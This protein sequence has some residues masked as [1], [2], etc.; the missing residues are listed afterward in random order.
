MKRKWSEYL[1]ENVKSTNF[2]MKITK[3]PHKTYESV[4]VAK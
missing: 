4:R 3:Q 2:A 1:V